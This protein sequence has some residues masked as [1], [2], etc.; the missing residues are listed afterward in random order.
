MDRRNFIG[1]VLGIVAGTQTPWKGEEPTYKTPL[2]EKRK[3]HLLRAFNLKQN[4]LKFFTCV[5]VLDTG[6]EIKAPAIKDITVHRTEFGHIYRIILIFKSINVM[7]AL[8]I[9]KIK[10][11]DDL[12]F[13][14]REDP[15]K[16][17]QLYI[18]DELN[19]TYSI[20]II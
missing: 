15:S 11:I 1:S 13:M 9:I 6:V 7:G 3:A 20:D 19:I 17:K 4:K 8:N 14:L 5:L 18:G 10:F 16:L 12:G 2:P